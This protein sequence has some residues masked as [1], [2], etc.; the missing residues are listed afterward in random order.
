MVCTECNTYKQVYCNLELQLF[1]IY[2]AYKQEINV[3]DVLDAPTDNEQV[4]VQHF[5]V[6]GKIEQT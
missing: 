2:K 4:L 1:F 6:R 5:T 3:V